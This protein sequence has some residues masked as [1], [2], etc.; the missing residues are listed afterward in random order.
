MPEIAACGD[1]GFCTAW[2]IW[3][4][5]ARLGCVAD[6]IGIIGSMTRSSFWF[7][8]TRKS[9]LPRYALFAVSLFQY[10]LAA[11][12]LQVEIRLEVEGPRWSGDDGSVGDLY[13]ADWLGEGVPGDCNGEEEP[14][15]VG[16]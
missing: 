14:V 4:A 13:D 9:L 6:S 11:S 10:L 2:P 15:G 1:V 3:Y 16:M 5:A 12:L 7:V 8:L